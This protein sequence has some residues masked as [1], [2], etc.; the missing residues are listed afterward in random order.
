MRDVFLQLLTCEPFNQCVQVKI[1][2][3][4][5]QRFLSVFVDR[6]YIDYYVLTIKSH[7]SM[8]FP[9]IN[10]IAKSC[11]ICLHPIVPHNYC[12]LMISPAALKG[13]RSRRA[14]TM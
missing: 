8:I 3:A 7:Y 4:R 2:Q 1:G 14:R 13:I 5:C 10:M 9:A 12:R 11:A 6:S